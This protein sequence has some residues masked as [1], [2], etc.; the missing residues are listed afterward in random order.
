MIRKIC[1]F[2]WMKVEMFS[3][4]KLAKDAKTS[5]NKVAEPKLWNV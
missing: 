3:I 5:V 4:P 2:G 1:S